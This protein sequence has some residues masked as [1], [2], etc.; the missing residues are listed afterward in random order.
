MG[1]ASQFKDQKEEIANLFLNEL[2]KMQSAEADE[3]D[4][5]EEDEEE[6]EGP[7]PKSL[8]E[9]QAQLKAELEKEENNGAL[10]AEVDSDASSSSSDDDDEEAG[11]PGM[12]L[13]MADEEYCGRD[14]GCTCILALYNRQLKRIMKAG[15]FLTDDG[16]VKGGLNLS[17][18]FGDHQYK[19]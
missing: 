13:S 16:R 17:R 19:D 11:K 15:G 9:R 4:E 8:T 18:A 6:D 14:S 5:E 7:K 3:E 1:N 12:P 2:A 10:I